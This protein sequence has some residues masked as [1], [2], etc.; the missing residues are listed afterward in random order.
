MWI[1]S[2]LMSPVSDMLINRGYMT[3]CTSRKLFN[4]ISHWGPA[5]LFIILPFTEN[6]G[7]VITLLTIG[8]GINAFSYVGYM[9]N[10]MDLSP[11][12][13]GSLMG[14]TNSI[15]NI[16]SILGPLTVGF[17]LTGSSNPSV[18]DAEWK[19]VFFLSAAIYI[20]GNLVFVIFGKA[21]IQK[22]N[23]PADRGSSEST[24]KAAKSN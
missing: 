14:F 2:L 19:T 20:I 1:L 6:A 11:N 18:V 9:C 23:E 7:V 3:T 22:W 13:S 12:F 24:D 5:I 16:M 10:H 8:V 21:E 17:I 4:S 15:A